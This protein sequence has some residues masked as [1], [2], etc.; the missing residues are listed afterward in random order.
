MNPIIWIIDEEWS[1]YELEKEVLLESFPESQIKFSSNDYE[2]DLESFG[3]LATAI[4][5]QISV[6]MGRQTIERLQNCKIISVYGAGYDKVDTVT[7]KE[8][9]I[10]VANVPGY[11]AEDV[12]DY[13][14]ACMY[15]FN[16]KIPDYASKVTD[17]PWGAMAAPKLIHRMNSLNLMIIGLGR[18]GTLLAKKAQAV[19]VK[20]TC[21]DPYVEEGTANQ[22][23][24]QKVELSEGL[25]KADFVSLNA[26]LCEETRGLMNYE[27]FCE[28]N[29]EAYFINASRG[30][31][32]V[33]KDLIRAV[34]EQKIS[35]AAL[36]VI[37]TEPPKKDDEI[38]HTPNI[39]VTPHISYLSE[40]S[41]KELQRT[42]AEN[43]VQYLMGKKL[44]SIVN[45]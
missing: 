10:V 35:G 34:R 26:K 25:Q 3:F 1:N 42:A 13:V 17:N 16:K 15:H 18:I 38:L 40:D 14:M 28:M 21:Y 2:K 36:D 30:G 45:P 39:L 8:M 33:Q 5:C 6:V 27:R 24:I 29:S 32:V 11:C 37:E 41:L 23:G 20:V 4:I 43:I 7:A 31:T 22:L 9:G 19:G 44:Y 12:S